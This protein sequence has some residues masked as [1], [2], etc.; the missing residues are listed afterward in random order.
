ME[1]DGQHAARARASPSASC[2]ARTMPSTTGFTHS[3]WLGFGATLDGQ[4][5]ARVAPGARRWRRGGTS[6]RPSPGWSPGSALPSNSEKIWASGLPT[7]LART[8]RRPRW[9]M[10][11]TASCTPAARGVVEHAVEERDER[12]AALEREALV[13]DVLRVQEALEALGLDQL[14]Q[15]APPRRRRR[16]AGGCGVDSMRSCSQSLR[17]RIGD[18]HVLD[19]DRAAVG[20]AQDLQDLAQGRPGPCPRGR[21]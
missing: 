5:L 15:D 2:L 1:Q 4:R 8:L 12:L 14:L 19:A 20:V 17:S 10:P 6:R 18:V 7:V 3:R 21:S 16:A 9:A 13:A 11:I